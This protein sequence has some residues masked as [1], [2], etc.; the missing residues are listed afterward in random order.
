M[1]STGVEKDLYGGLIRLHVLH[2]A[3]Q[4]PVYGL[5]LI[6]ELAHHGYQVGPGT[7]YPIL[8]GL[9]R[10]GYLASRIEK[11]GARNRRVYRATRAGCRELRLAKGRVTELFREL[12]AEESDSSAPTGRPTKRR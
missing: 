8:H 11:A 4:E 6:E 7:M 3:C 12:L 2:H 10:A 1:G 5:H 9:E